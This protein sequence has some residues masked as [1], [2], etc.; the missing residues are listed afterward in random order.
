[1]RSSQS[2]HCEFIETLDAHT[3]AT[4]LKNFLCSFSRASH[5][6]KSHSRTMSLA[7]RIRGDVRVIKF[8]VVVVVVFQCTSTS[9]QVQTRNFSMQKL[10]RNG[11][12]TNRE[13]KVQRKTNSSVVISEAEFRPRF[14]TRFPLPSN[15][16]E[17]FRFIQNSGTLCILRGFTLFHK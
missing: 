11:D 16:R 6:S 15:T 12:G 13:K 10:G 8:F 1:M 7:T 5:L 2:L 4:S 14:L 3:K 9:R 17:H